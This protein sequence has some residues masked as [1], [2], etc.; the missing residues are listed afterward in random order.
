MFWSELMDSY[1][2]QCRMDWGLPDIWMSY[3]GVGGRAE[4]ACQR[5][6]SCGRSLNPNP[7]HSTSGGGVRPP[8]RFVT[9]RRST[10][11]SLT[12]TPLENLTEGIPQYL[13][14]LG[15]RPS[16]LFY[17]F[18]TFLIHLAGRGGL[19]SLPQTLLRTAATATPGNRGDGYFL[20]LPS[21]QIP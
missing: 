13:Y 12:H 6:I 14:Y 18:F 10:P 1:G 16:I 7:A 21:L 9:S 11:P 20:A 15:I 19:E 17:I 3:V 2:L 8:L 5:E 4:G